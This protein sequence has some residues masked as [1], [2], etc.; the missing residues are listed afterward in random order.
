MDS[1]RSLL[2]FDAFDPFTGDVLR[3]HYGQDCALNNSLQYR[4]LGRVR[5]NR[6]TA[7]FGFASAPPSLTRLLRASGLIPR[8]RKY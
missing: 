6:V 1:K 8:E 5:F 4:E 2:S 7:H 3:T